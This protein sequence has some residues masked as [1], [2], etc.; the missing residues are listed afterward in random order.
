LT[1]IQPP[2]VSSLCP[3]ISLHIHPWKKS[4]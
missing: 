1:W 2:S 3:C 4:K